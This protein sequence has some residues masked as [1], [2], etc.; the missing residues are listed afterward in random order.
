MDSAGFRSCTLQTRQMQLRH[1]RVHFLMQAQTSVLSRH[2]MKQ[3]CKRPKRCHVHT[4]ASA[5]VF[6]LDFDGVLV[7]SEPEVTVSCSLIDAPRLGRSHCMVCPNKSEVSVRTL[8]ISSSAIAAAAEYWP[9][10][11]GKLDEAAHHQVRH[12]LRQVRPVLVNG[13]EALIMV[14]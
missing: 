1:N 12:N 13:V 6:A 8:Q 5:D 4:F 11:F 3:H 2:G 10:H 7:D 9:E 14:G